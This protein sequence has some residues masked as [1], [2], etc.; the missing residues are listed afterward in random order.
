MEDVDGDYRELSPLLLT[1][2]RREG[3]KFV[4]KKDNN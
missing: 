2:G 3:D 4:L 1:I